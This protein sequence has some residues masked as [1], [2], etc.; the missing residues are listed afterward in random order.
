MAFLQRGILLAATAAAI[1]FPSAFNRPEERRAGTPAATVADKAADTPVRRGDVKP[2]PASADAQGRYAPTALEHYL[3]NEVIYYVRPGLKLK[4][5]SITIGADRK[6]VVDFTIT[7]DLDQPLDRL[8]KTTP[9]A[10]SLSFILAWWNPASGRYTAYTTRNQT[11]PITGQTAV[12]AGTDSGGVFKDLETGHSIYTFAKVLPADFDVT[13]THTLGIYGTRNTTDIL[14]KSYYVNVE[15]DF[16]PDAQAVTAK[17]DR[18]NAT[19][20]CNNCHEQLAFHGGSRRDVKLC[21][22][23]HTPQTT[24]PD[25][26][27]TVDLAVM[28]H[29]IHMGEELPS[30]QAGKPYQII[31]NAQSL[32]DFSTV[33]Y[34]QDIRNCANCHEGTGTAAQK[35]TQSDIWYTKPSIASCGSCHDTVNFT[36][37]A[38]HAAGPATDATCASCHR[39][40]GDQEWDAS[41]KGA[42]TVP[43]DSTQL[44]GLRAEII[45][46]DQVGAGKKPVVTFKLSD[47]TGALDPKPF[48]SNFNILM[49]GPTTDYAV[50]PVRQNASGATFNGTVG[51]YTLTTAIPADASGT[52][53]FSIEARRTVN[54]LHADGTTEA[55]S[56]A[57]TNPVFYAAVTGA[58]KPRRESA[59]L[60][61]CN[62]CHDRLALHGGQRVVVQECVIC[63]N[64]NGDDS[65]RRPA[66][67]GKPESIDFRRLI[68]RIH[69]GEELTQD[70]T[71]YGFGSSVNNFNEVR[72]PMDRRNCI[73]CH[74]NAASYALPTG[75]TLN[76]KT[77]RDFFTPQGPGTA[78]CLGCHDNRDAAAHAYLNTA[79]FGEACATCHGTG[80]DWA[81]EKVH[82]R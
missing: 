79:P 21:V 44:K 52:W 58:V 16:R 6:A 60:V 71:I 2:G 41:I 34:P 31:G 55:F 35:P 27:N 22:L 74:T 11:S 82:A 19:V 51:T 65:A 28:V 72:F 5:N 77:E 10:V 37:G 25:T 3:A 63:H 76:V 64:P 23:C 48:G 32:H 7:D 26:G 66:T 49:N 75:G 40:V 1:A 33:A 46:V 69:T 59:N 47:S 8:G 56:E 45:S 29:K 67:A 61:S 24:D 20:S 43:Y 53:V 62:K 18:I 4:V 36:T 81:V 68:H 38:N 17:W 54:L 14:G 42:H 80:A 78:A 70:F 15:Q 50:Q 57:A 73:G 30:V 39:P 9:G 12:Q 13:K